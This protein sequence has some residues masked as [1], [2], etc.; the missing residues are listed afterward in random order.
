[1]LGILLKVILFI[2]IIGLVCYFFS[3]SVDF[4]DLYE[5]LYNFSKVQLIF[6]FS[7]S[8]LIT[9]LKSLRFLILVRS[10]GINISFW[11]NFKV[12]ASSQAITPLPGGEAGRGML[13]SHESGGEISK[14]SGVV[15]AQSGLELVV[16]S[17]LALLGS[18]FFQVFIFPSFIM[19]TVIIFLSYIIIHQRILKWVLK[20]L[21]NY[22][23]LKKLKPKLIESQKVLHQSLFLS[24]GKQ[25]IPKP[26]LLRVVMLTVISNL[27]GGFLIY[28]IC[29][30]LGVD[31][32]IF[33]ATFV[34]CLSAVIQGIS[35]FS[36]GG[37]GLTESGMTGALLLSEI[38][39]EK[40]IGIVLLFR[41]STLAF[42]V[43]F[44]LTFLLIF[45]SRSL[46]FSKIRW[47][48]RR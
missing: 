35:V 43:V 15:F 30:D 46:L 37:I 24:K 1:M 40:S 9:I 45:Y 2:L 25:I 34:Y 10:V 3:K 6:F 17:C 47:R 11:D 38:S 27:F 20:F 13:L 36:P 12:F 33:R 4:D 29:R 14:I 16:G 7:I 18:L 19:F 28:V 23:F 31:L 42:Y 39:L 44:G 22:S 48:S 21:P 5:T 26:T 8:L 41:I 32:N